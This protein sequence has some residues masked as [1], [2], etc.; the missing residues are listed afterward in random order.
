MK[1][2]IE[3]DVEGETAIQQ[4][5]SL[6]YGKR[7]YIFHRNDKGFLVKITIIT[8]APDPSRFYT[9]L[10][11]GENP[12]ITLGTDQELHKQ[13][14]SE[15]QQMEGLLAFHFRVSRIRW[16]TARSESVAETDEE[17]GLGAYRIQTTRFI[18][19][20]RAGELKPE[21]LCDLM[22][23][24][25]E[26][27]NLVVP[28]SFW[29]NGNTDLRSFRFINA[30]FNF[31]FVLEGWYANGKT[32]KDQVRKQF[33]RSGQ[34]K[35]IIGQILPEHLDSGRSPSQ[36]L[37]ALERRKLNSD[38]NGIIDLLIDTRGEVHHFSERSTRLQGTPLNHDDYEEVAFLAGHIATETLRNRLANEKIPASRR[39][40]M[41]SKD[42]IGQ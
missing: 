3:A 21:A 32:Q 42:A 28:L 37:Q 39:E 33:T 38:V 8:P 12:G 19:E 10:Q 9:E 11:I 6:K 24:L 31:Y 4:T 36:L 23:Q 16:D 2:L 27:Q 40:S 41:Q 26:Y 7:E 29:R 20:W 15:L 22:D 5:T 35:Q 30:F 18:P 25:I 17:R 13:L 34:L 1:Y 14:L